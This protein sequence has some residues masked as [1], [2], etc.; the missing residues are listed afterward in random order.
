MPQPDLFNYRSPR[1][2]RSKPPQEFK[3]IALREGP[4]PSE[5]ILCDTPEDLAAYWRSHVA[6]APWYRDEQEC[7]VAI[8]INV[9]RRV[10][11]HHLVT[12]GVLDQ[13]FAH[14]RETFRT[15]IV[16]AAHSMAIGHNHPSGDPTPSESDIKMTRDLIRAG[17]I[18]KIE[19]IDH[20][21]IG[22]TTHVSLRS[23]GYFSI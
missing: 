11:G 2:R 8:F 9:R 21:I 10:L 19:L 12:L 4:P 17:Q 20:V 15:A 6:T 16:L 1:P 14:P 3:V 5:R 7:F 23:L 18:L 13:V 22:H